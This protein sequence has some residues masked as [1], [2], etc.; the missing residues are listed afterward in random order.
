MDKQTYIQIDRIEAKLD[1]LIQKL[2]PNELKEDEDGTK[3]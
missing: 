1:F 3:I 2:L